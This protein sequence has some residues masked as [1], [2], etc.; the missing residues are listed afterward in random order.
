[1]TL[2]TDENNLYDKLDDGKFVASREAILLLLP[3]LFPEG[4]SKFGSLPILEH[5][6]DETVAEIAMIWLEK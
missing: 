4:S 2:K 3:K 6:I 5:F 1:M